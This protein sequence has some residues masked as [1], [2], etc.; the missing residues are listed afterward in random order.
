MIHADAT[1]TGK[2][3]AVRE[4]ILPRHDVVHR[5]CTTDSSRWVCLQALEV[6]HQS[7]FRR[8]GHGRRLQL[9]PG[10]V[11]TPAR[12]RTSH[13]ARRL[14]GTTTGPA[15][16]GSTAKLPAPST[17]PCRPPRPRPE[18][19]QRPVQAGEHASAARVAACRRSPSGTLGGLAPGPMLRCLAPPRLPHRV[20]RAGLAMPRTGFRSPLV[21]WIRGGPFLGSTSW[22]GVRG[23]APS[24]A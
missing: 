15:M 21:V 14:P 7:A 2:R 23:C 22:K 20:L 24:S 13:R 19:S 6:A 3:L 16:C 10:E 18:L 4:V 5:R 1:G 11:L 9:W 12:R 8:G 17:L